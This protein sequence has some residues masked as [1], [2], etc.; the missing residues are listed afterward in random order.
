MVEVYKADLALFP[1]PPSYRVITRATEF[2]A[3][4]PGFK[5]LPKRV[6]YPTFESP[7]YDLL[8]MTA[9]LC[10]SLHEIEVDETLRQEYCEFLKSY[11]FPF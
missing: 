3:A 5:D 4:M 2:G 6:E 11:P 8:Y 7:N 1:L 9:R 10:R